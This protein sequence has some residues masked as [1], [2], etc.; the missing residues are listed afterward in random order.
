MSSPSTRRE[1][2]WIKVHLIN[3]VVKPIECLLVQDI[4]RVRAVS[5]KGGS[6]FSDFMLKAFLE[7]IRGDL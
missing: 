6:Y 3:G 5:G 4:E 1:V 7:S 2:S